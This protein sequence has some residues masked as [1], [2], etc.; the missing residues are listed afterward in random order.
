M[1]AVVNV[2]LPESR[3]VEAGFRP[4]M[5]KGRYKHESEDRGGCSKRCDRFSQ[6]MKNVGWDEQK[7]R[8]SNKR[9]TLLILQF[10]GIDE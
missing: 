8:M 4:R 9:T 1:R 2:Q 6:E 3:A 5:R 10:A 7:I